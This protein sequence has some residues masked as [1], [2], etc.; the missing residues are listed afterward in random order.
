MMKMTEGEGAQNKTGKTTKLLHQYIFKNIQCSIKKYI[1]QV[2]IFKLLH[3]RINNDYP[4]Y[5]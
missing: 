4:Y 2:K 5:P 3:C 1:C